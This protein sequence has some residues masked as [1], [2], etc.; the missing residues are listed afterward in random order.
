MESMLLCGMKTLHLT[1]FLK[2]V[3]VMW[4]IL[5]IFIAVFDPPDAPVL[6]VDS[7]NFFSV[8]L[9]WQQPNVVRE[10]VDFYIVSYTVLN[11]T[12][13]GT[14]VTVLPPEEV[15]NEPST[16]RTKTI[17]LSSNTRYNFTVVAQNSV[18]FSDPSNTVTATTDPQT[19][20]H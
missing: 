10:A 11:G 9:R 5:Y 14:S 7:V 3:D 17:N 2:Y 16:T 18:G 4:Y 20:K 12:D 15:S 19:G 13:D 8:Q 1:Y 6:S